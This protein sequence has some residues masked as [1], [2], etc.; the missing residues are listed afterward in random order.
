MTTVRDVHPY[1]LREV[2]EVTGRNR[3]RIVLAECSPRPEDDEDIDALPL[4]ERAAI[5]AAIFAS[6]TWA[7]RGDIDDEQAW[8]IV[9]RARPGVPFDRPPIDEQFAEAEARIR[10]G[11]VTP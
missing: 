5:M 8:P 9:S 7:V 10:T 1:V 11:E 4:I 6:N 2:R 3:G